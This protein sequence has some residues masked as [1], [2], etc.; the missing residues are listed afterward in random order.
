MDGLT[1]LAEVLKYTSPVA[2][3]LI[4]YAQQKNAHPHKRSSKSAGKRG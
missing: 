4:M 3:A 2:V 1:F